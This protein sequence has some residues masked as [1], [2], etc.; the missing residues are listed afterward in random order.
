MTDH[1][2][3]Q[4]AAEPNRLGLIV[5]GSLTGGLD[6]R[7]DSHRSVEEMAVGRYVTIQGERA[8]FFG[9]ITDVQLKSTNERLKIGRAHV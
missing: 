9:I 6:V 2:H 3:P 4:P 8:R 5:S 7:L 1:E